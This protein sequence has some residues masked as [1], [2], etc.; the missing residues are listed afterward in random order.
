MSKAKIHYYDIG[1]YLSREEKLKIIKEFGSV[2]N[3]PWKSLKPNEHGDW[4]NQRNESFDE[5][6]PIQPEK[7]FDVKSQSF[8]VAYS[9]GLGT[10]RDAWCYNSSKQ[11]LL[12]NINKT[13]SFYNSERERFLK[14][15]EK[16]LEEIEIDK[17]LTFDSKKINWTDTWKRD[18]IKNRKYDSDENCIT[19]GIYR[20]FFKQALYFS[21]TLNHR[22]YQQPKIFP[23]SDIKNLVICLTGKGASKDF[24][25]LISNSIANL[26]SIEKAQCFPLYHYEERQVEN[27]GLFDEGGQSEYIQRDGV[28]DFILERARK[29]YGNN[30]NKEDIFYYVYGLLHSQQYRETFKNDLKKMLPRIP[31]V[32]GARDFWKFSKAGRALADLHINYESVPPLMGVRVL[33]NGVLAAPDT[34]YPNPHTLYEV[35]KMR[36]PKKGQKDT[37]IYNSK[38]IIENIPDKAYEYVVNGKSAIEWIMERYQIKTDKKSGIKNDPNDWSKEVGNPRYILDLLLSIIN[39]SVQ[40]VDIVNGLP[41]LE[42]E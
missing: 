23:K 17:F 3:V 41:E 40:T 6:I 37:I 33:V 31:L 12:E 35:E 19:E 42:F 11:N 38:V 1:D 36:F 30:V 5:F 22:V 9:L 32:D 21:P 24:S 4:I 16:T 8:F 20:P 14:D 10:N 18:L 2:S 7:K 26:D 29:A 15:S 28:S 13:V 39:V 34:P 27:P 25:V